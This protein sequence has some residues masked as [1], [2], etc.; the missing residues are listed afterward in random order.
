MSSYIG[1]GSEVNNILLLYS[2]TAGTSKGCLINLIPAWPLL[3]HWPD[4]RPSLRT[5][6]PDHSVDSNPV[7]LKS[8][9]PL[10]TA[11]ICQTSS[12]QSW[13]PPQRGNLAFIFL[14]GGGAS[15]ETGGQVIL[16]GQTQ[17][18]KVRFEVSASRRIWSMLL[19]SP[20][21]HSSAHPW[22]PETKQAKSW[23]WIR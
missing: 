12:S 3:I 11:A 18:S 9:S 13:P 21:I 2:D 16:L 4:V 22:N 23:I 20:D 14:K 1:A 7:T 17:R 19:S 5:D 8:G 10:T 6:R 15:E